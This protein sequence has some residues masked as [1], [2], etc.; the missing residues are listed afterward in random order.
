V[1][2]VVRRIAPGDDLDRAGLIV[3]SAYEALPGHYDDPGY[4]QLLADVRGRRDEIDIV[5]AIDDQAPEPL[6]G[7]LSFLPAPGG[8]HYEFDDDDATSFRYFGVA[9]THQGRG[10][11]ETM[12]RWCIEETERL[13]RAR[14]RIHT[15]VNMVGAQRLY[16]RLGFVRDLSQ[17]G[18]WGGI[19]GLSYVYHL[20]TD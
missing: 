12:V 14:I 7:C 10:V 3:R 6:V 2:I 15:L 9:A 4:D 19:I 17:D 5:V 18:D 8:K 11:G 1:S 16:E 20:R 13:G